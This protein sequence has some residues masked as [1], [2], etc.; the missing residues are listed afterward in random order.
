MLICI[1]RLLCTNR[2]ARIG[3]CALR[4]GLPL[5]L[6]NIAPLSMNNAAMLGNRT[7]CR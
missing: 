4:I 7:A 6:P 3:D 5:L 1:K 2:D